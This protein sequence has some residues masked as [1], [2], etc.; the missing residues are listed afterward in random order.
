M[1]WMPFSGKNKRFNVKTRVLIATGCGRRGIFV[2]G[3][4]GRVHERSTKSFFI[5]FLRQD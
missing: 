4:K 2:S 5:I 3:G 1:Y